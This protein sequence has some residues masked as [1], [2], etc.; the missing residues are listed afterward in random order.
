MKKEENDDTDLNPQRRREKF[1][2]ICT[3]VVTALLYAGLIAWWHFHTPSIDLRVQAPGADNRPEGKTRS[4]NDVLIGEFFMRYADETSSLQGKWRCFRGQ[5]F[6]NVVRTDDKINLS[7]ES[8]PVEWSFETGEGHAA[9]V[10][11]NGRV[12][13]LDYDEKLSSDALRCFALESGRELW[14]RWYRVPMKRNHGFSRTAPAA[15]EKY[16]ITVGPQGHV[17]C[18]DPDDGKMKWTL[19]M[20]KH[21]KTEVPFW[22]SGQCPRIDGSTLVLAPAG[23]SV[24]LA[25]ID[26]E[27]GAMLWT[28]PNSPRFKMSHSSIT[29]MTL[30]GKKTYVYAGVGGVCGISAE[31]ADAGAL[32]WS[33]DKW[34]PSVIAPSPLQVSP[35]EIFMVAGYGTGGA[36]MT[37]V[38]SGANWN[39]AFRERYKPAEGMSSEQQTPIL[40]ND[41]LIGIMPKDGGVMRGRLVCHSP[42]DLHS[43]V[44]TSDERFGL[45]PYLVVNNSLFVFNDDG[46]LFVYDILKNGLKLRKRQR[47]MDG[48]D[49]WGP[50]AYADG[51]LIVRDAHHVCCL[52]ITI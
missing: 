27:T 9:P 43:P 1:T 37:V 21:L 41:M 3:T 39:V 50:M 44:W 26:C 46:E 2:L 25:G 11:F 17:M 35:S 29:P 40:Y 49:A 13:V 32:L 18:C 28:T 34:Q 6:S 47:V 10:I 8:Y 15:G 22:Y 51:R 30:S 14:R 52:K 19:D 5:D 36:L 16:V 45:G 23:D 33:I 20:R 31:P 7:D 48:V 12:Y 24:L 4:A 42:S 38:K